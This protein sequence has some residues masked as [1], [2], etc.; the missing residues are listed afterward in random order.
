M[1][2]NLTYSIIEA[3]LKQ[4]MYILVNNSLGFISYMSGD[5]AVV[6]YYYNDGKIIKLARKELTTDIVKEQFRDKVIK[7]IAVVGNNPISINH[8]CYKKLFAPMLTFPKE[9]DISYIQTFLETHEWIHPILGEITSVYT[10]LNEGDTAVINTLDAVDRLE[11]YKIEDRMVTVIA[12]K[13]NNKYRV[14]INTLDKEVVVARNELWVAEKDKHNLFNI[15]DFTELKSLVDAG[16]VK[17]IQSKG[18]AEPSEKKEKV[19][20]AFHKVTP[21]D[22]KA[23]YVR[24]DDGSYHWMA[25]NE[26]ENLSYPISIPLENPPH[27]Q[28]SGYDNDYWIPGTIREQQKPTSDCKNFVPFREGLPIFGSVTKATIGDTEFTYFLLDNVKQES[29]NKYIWKHRDITE[30][31]RS[32]LTLNRLVKI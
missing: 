19:G 6:S 28:F 31:R 25:V 17:P 13:A 12:K 18:K 21:S 4:G 3:E 9:G 23:R 24:A 1:I 22:W 26:K 2:A 10:G 20:N 5:K 30:E 8:Q 11:L 7:L 32:T 15:M 27:Y 29:V 14:R 16:A